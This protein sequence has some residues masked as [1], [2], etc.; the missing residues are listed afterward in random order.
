[1]TL[2][3]DPEEQPV[4]PSA[5]SFTF[6]EAAGLAASVAA[7]PAFTSEDFSF[8]LQRRPGAYLWLG[9][10]RAVSESAIELPLHHSC[11]D[12]NDDA[13]PHGIRWFCAVAERELGAD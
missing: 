8:L 10:R 5:G 11:Y 4:A 1:M 12:F 9:Q 13:L 6:A 3:P 2:R 7:R